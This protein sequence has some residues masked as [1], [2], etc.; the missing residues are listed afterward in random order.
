LDSVISNSGN[1]SGSGPTLAVT[2]PR[3]IPRRT[4][5]LTVCAWNSTH[6]RW[7]TKGPVALT[8]WPWSWTFTV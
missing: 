2:V 5:L 3:S 1:N 7:W 6:L 4:P 8:L